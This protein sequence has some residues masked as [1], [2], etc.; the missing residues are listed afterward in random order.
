MLVR[1]YWSSGMV[2]GGDD[3]IEAAADK[4]RQLDLQGG[5][6]QLLH[7]AISSLLYIWKQ[8][9]PLHISA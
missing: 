2:G 6:E 7:E 8:V 1:Q 9:F 3:W 5:A 4:I